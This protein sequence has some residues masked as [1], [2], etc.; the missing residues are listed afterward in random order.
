MII[1]LQSIDFTADFQA[2]LKII[3]IAGLITLNQGLKDFKSAALK[4]GNLEVLTPL[5]DIKLN[6][7]HF[8]KQVVGTLLQ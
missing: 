5:K 3:G 4:E 7:Q 6:G 8:A 2:I 1:E